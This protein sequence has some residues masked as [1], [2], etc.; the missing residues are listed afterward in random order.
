MSTLTKVI[1]SMLTMAI[2]I[3]F[4]SSCL[5]SQSNTPHLLSSQHISTAKIHTMNSSIDF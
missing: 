2:A 5:F 3:A 4:S 1:T